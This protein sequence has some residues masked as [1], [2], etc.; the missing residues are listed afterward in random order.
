MLCFYELVVADMPVPL[1]YV[2]RLLPT[3]LRAVQRCAKHMMGKPASN[4]YCRAFRCVSASV[5][6]LAA[7]PGAVFDQQATLIKSFMQPWL[8]VARLLLGSASVAQVKLK[9]HSKSV[10]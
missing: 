4:L 8:Q 3:L 6:W 2:P 5:R 9:Q 1:Q 10:Y 7:A